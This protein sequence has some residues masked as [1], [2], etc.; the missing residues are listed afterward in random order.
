MIQMGK[1]ESHNMLPLCP[2]GSQVRIVVA[3]HLLQEQGSSLPVPQ[4]VPSPRSPSLEFCSLQGQAA[5]QRALPLEG[6]E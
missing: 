5:R 6:L 2:H 1:I 3:S 4:V